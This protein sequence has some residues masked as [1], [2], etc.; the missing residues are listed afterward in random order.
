[1]KSMHWT[2]MILLAALLTGCATVKGDFCDLAKPI[3]WDTPQQLNETPEPII[4]QIVQHNEVH[5][6]VCK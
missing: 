4:R 2:L 1:M 3:W 6:L 5:K